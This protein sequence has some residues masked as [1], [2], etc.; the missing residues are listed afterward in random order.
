MSRA[1]YEPAKSSRNAIAAYWSKQLH[2]TLR[3]D[4]PFDLDPDRCWACNH[5]GSGRYPLHRCHL[6][7]AG[8]GRVQNL[9]ILC[10]RCHA[11]QEKRDPDEVLKWIA[12]CQGMELLTPPPWWE[13]MAPTKQLRFVISELKKYHQTVKIDSLRVPHHVWLAIQDSVWELRDDWHGWNYE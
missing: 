9:V 12:D 11:W 7:A 6:V 13:S 2:V 1:N 10:Q 8:P 3:D 4:E 5:D